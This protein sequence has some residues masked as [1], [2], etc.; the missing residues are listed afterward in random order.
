MYRRCPTGEVD[1][2]RH[3]LLLRCLHLGNVL[4]CLRTRDKG[5]EG[6]GDEYREVRAVYNM[7]Y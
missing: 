2:G 4:K 1:L 6:V 7:H 3:A 5:G